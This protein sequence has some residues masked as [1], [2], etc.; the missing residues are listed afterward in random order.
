MVRICHLEADIDY[1]LDIIEN[2]G[3]KKTVKKA[4]KNAK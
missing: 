3:K 2:K 4:K 1:I